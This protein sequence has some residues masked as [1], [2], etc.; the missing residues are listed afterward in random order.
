M[1]PVQAF[2]QIVCHKLLKVKGDCKIL[3]TFWH[4]LPTSHWLNDFVVIKSLTPPFKTVTSFMNEPYVNKGKKRF[5]FRWNLFSDFFSVQHV[6]TRYGW[7]IWSYLTSIWRVRL[8]N[9]FKSFFSAYEFVLSTNFYPYS[10][11]QGCIFS[12]LVIRTHFSGFE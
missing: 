3:H 2:K 5:S 7:L 8:E 12:T 4:Y 10:T 9:H 6:W 1:I 11:N